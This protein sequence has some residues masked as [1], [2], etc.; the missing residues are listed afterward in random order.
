MFNWRWRY[1]AW[2]SLCWERA[3]LTQVAAAADKF[4]ILL[5]AVIAGLLAGSV[6]AWSRRCPLSPLSLHLVWLVPLAFLP[7]WAAFYLPATRRLAADNAAAAAL[8]S[9][10]VLL[11]IFAWYNRDRPGFC[12]LGIGLA[13]NLLVITLNGG[14]M[15]IS[16]ET[17]AQLR[18]HA[19]PD[20]WQVGSRLGTGK[21]IV[22]PVAVTRLWWLSDRFLLPAG[23][24]YRVAFSLGD[25]FI[26]SGA[27]WLLWMLGEDTR[28]GPKRK[29]RECDLA[30]LFRSFVL[31]QRTEPADQRGHSQQR[32]L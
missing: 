5:F 23:F 17:L 8:V 21:D 6:R 30:T 10:Q 31:R 27:F 1:S 26:A 29:T 28:Y 16:P 15:P 9:S 12:A 7:Q 25:V 3:R 11:L 24:P 20:A 19:P 32:I 22:L 18:P 2:F 4:V 13:M 14:L